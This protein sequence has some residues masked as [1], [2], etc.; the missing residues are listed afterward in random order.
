MSRENV[1]LFREAT[2][3]F[4]RRDRAPWLGKRVR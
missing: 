2:D 1:A 4:N 3:A